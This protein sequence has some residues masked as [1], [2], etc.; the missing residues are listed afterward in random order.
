MSSI[1]PAASK[2]EVES[3]KPLNDPRDSRHI[4][5]ANSACRPSPG[6]PTTLRQARVLPWR[7]FP[8]QTDPCRRADAGQV[9]S[10]H[11]PTPFYSLP[12]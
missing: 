6:D 5:C 3:A 1:Q 4:E 7:S 8:L 11:V 12:L 9:A 2:A 10:T